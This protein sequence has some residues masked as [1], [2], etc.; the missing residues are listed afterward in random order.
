[1]NLSPLETCLDDKIE[2]E[3]IQSQQIQHTYFQVVRQLAYVHIEICNISGIATNTVKSFIRAHERPPLSSLFCS[4]S[5]LQ[6]SFSPSLRCHF[7]SLYRVFVPRIY[8]NL[9]KH[10]QDIYEI[11]C[12]IF[13]RYF[14]DQSYLSSC[15]MHMV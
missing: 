10:I 14:V 7:L 5:T 4:F 12:G 11:F 6:P 2:Q 15:K 1:M 3:L 9:V 13:M 8:L